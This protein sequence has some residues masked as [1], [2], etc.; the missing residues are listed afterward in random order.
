MPNFNT[1]KASTHAPTYTIR[2][3]TGDIHGSNLPISNLMK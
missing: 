3:Y 2:H 1:F